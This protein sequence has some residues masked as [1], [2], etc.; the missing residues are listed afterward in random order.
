MSLF[1]FFKKPDWRSGEWDADGI[2]DQRKLVIVAKKAPHWQARETAIKKLNARHQALFASIAKNGETSNERQAAARQLTDQTLL[3]DLVRNG[4]DRHVRFLAAEKLD[5]RHQA[6]FCSLVKNDNDP[7]I[8]LI[9]ISKLDK[10]HQALAQAEC[11]DIVKYNVNSWAREAAMKMLTE[12]PQA[13]Y[14]V[15]AKK[16]TGSPVGEMAVS[17]LNDQALLADVAQNSQDWVTRIAAI[18]K[19]DERHQTIFANIARHDKKWR[20]CV[21]AILK[22]D[23]QNQ[24]LLA[25]VAKNDDYYESRDS[26]YDESVVIFDAEAGREAVN[27]LTD[28][29]L[30]VDVAKNAKGASVREAAARKLEELARGAQ[31]ITNREQ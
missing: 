11:V 27:K 20:V 24:T 1:N 13:F 26:S 17:K 22:L 12:Q 14:A 5:E 23:G 30:L 10:Q 7:G 19:L 29:V 15:I 28:Q 4:R 21:A 16:E 18:E 31:A 25:D 3:A 6:L 2:T 8:R 9:I